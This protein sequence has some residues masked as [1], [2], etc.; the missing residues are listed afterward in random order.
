MPISAAYRR[1][2]AIR[3]FIGMGE[4]AFSRLSLREKVRKHGYSYLYR[5]RSFNHYTDYK[6]KRR[7]GARAPEAAY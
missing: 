2:T 7:T 1:S 6:S 5:S 4:E 3:I